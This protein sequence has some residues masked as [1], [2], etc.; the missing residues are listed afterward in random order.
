MNYL[1]ELLEK[2]GLQEGYV[3]DW[4]DGTITLDGCFALAFLRELADI[5]DKPEPL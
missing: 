5:L 2:H 4:G 1:N 3:C